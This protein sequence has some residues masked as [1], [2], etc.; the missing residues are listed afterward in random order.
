MDIFVDQ[1]TVPA[2][3]FEFNHFSSQFYEGII[4]SFVM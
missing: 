4:F 2:N 1:T 3:L